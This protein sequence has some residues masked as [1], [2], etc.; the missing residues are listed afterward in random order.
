M[1]N[2]PRVLMDK[3]DCMQKPMADV[4]REVGILRKPK[5]NARDTNTVTQM[6]NASDGLSSTLDAG[7]ERIAV[8]EDLSIFK[9]KKQRE[10]LRKTEQNTQEL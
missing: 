2:M 3:V 1:I 9:M 4:G 5:R 8:L 10:Q 7:E 6:K